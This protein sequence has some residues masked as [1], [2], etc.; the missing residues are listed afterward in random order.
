MKKKY[1]ILMVGMLTIYIVSCTKLDQNL[2]GQLSSSSTE[3]SPDGLLKGVYSALSAPIQPQ[4]KLWALSQHTTDE[5]VGPTRAGDWDDN[6]IWRVLHAHTWNAEHAYALNTWKDLLNVQFQATTTIESTT[7]KNIV[8]EA[9]FLRALSM[10]YLLDCWDQVPFRESNKDLTI[11]PTVKKGVECVNYIISEL[12]SILNDLPDYSNANKTKA[13]KVAART[14]LMKLY[15]NKGVYANRATPTFA[16]GDMA[17]VLENATVIN[18]VKSGLDTNY[19]ENFDPNNDGT[20]GSDI[21]FSLSNIPGTTSNNNVRSRWYC[22]MHYNQTPSGWN[23]FTTLGEF[24]DNFSSTDKRR[25]GNYQGQTNVSGVK[26]GFLIGQQYDQ[27][28]TALKDRTGAALS[29]TRDVALIEK[30][31][32]LE[33]TGIRVI[34]YPIDYVSTGDDKTNDYVIFRFADVALM[35]A[36]AA[37]RTG[38]TATALPLYNGLRSLRIANYTSTSTVTLDDIYKERGREFYWEGWRRNDMIRFGKFLSS[39]TLK[40]GVS[41]VKYLLFGIHPQQLALN[42]NLKQNP[43]Y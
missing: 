30:G 42:P 7:D 33:V 15:L 1:I 29:F 5:T 19:F 39:R 14:L 3:I 38:N 27:T 28:G 23:G 35:A 40:T 20:K 10:F 4:D 18:S 21:I 12:E 13:N 8:A 43:G 17:K 37:L 22:T 32:N 26:V 34:K 25:G 24:Y 2:T 9:K 6:G 11:V 41:D 31:A 16:P 36:E